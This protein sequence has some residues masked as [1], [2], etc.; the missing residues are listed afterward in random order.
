M[1]IGIA[2]VHVGLARAK[3]ATDGPARHRTVAIFFT[4][5]MLAMLASIPWPGRPYARPLIRW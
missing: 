4:L 3:R 1:V 5:A 2:L